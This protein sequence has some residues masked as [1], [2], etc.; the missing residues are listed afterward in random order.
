MVRPSGDLRQVDGS[1]IGSP[2]VGDVRTAVLAAREARRCNETNDC[3]LTQSLDCHPRPTYGSGPMPGLTPN[4][5]SEEIPSETNGKN[6]GM[7]T[8]GKRSSDHA[9]A[10]VTRFAISLST[11]PW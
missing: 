4:S 6:D 7:P 9:F 8:W 11:Q 3:R 1:T 10:R 5:S 2:A